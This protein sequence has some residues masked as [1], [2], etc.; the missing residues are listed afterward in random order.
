MKAPFARLSIPIELQSSDRAIVPAAYMA[1]TVSP[2]ITIWRKMSIIL[3]SEIS[4]QQVRV[5]TQA[6][7]RS[8]PNEFAVV[9]NINVIGDFLQP[10]GVL[11]DDNERW[12]NPSQVM[13][14]FVHLVDKFWSQ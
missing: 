14:R 7:R 1:P 4:P 13:Q 11:L 2:L 8:V 10:L 6:C 5:L 9:N 12:G 3:R